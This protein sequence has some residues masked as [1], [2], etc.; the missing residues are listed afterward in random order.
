MANEDVI[1]QHIVFS[2]ENIEN[3][4]K[5]QVAPMQRPNRDNVKYGTELSD[6]V[7]I[8]QGNFEES[9]QEKPPEFDPAFIFKIK[10]D[11]GKIGDDD[12]QRSGI[13]LLSENPDGFVVL[14]SQ[15]QLKTFQEKIAGYGEEIAG[16]QKNPRYAWIAS[17]ATEMGLWNRKDRI[18][19]KLSKIDINPDADYILDVELWHYGT[20]DACRVRMQELHK[21]TENNGGSLFDYYIGSNLSV[22]R[23]MV[24]GSVL[25]LLL[26]VEIIERID[27]PPQPELKIA[28]IINTP[29]DDFPTPITNPPEGSPGICIVDSGIANGHPMLGAAIGDTVAI[30][31]SLG[32]GLDDNGHGTRVA[33]IALYGNVQDCIQKLNFSPQFF[34][35]GARVTNAQNRFD[36][37]HL[38]VKQMD[39]AIRYFHKNY[40]CRIFNISLGD[41][42]LIYDDGKPSQWA[43]ILDTLAQEL[44]ILIVV[45][46][47][48]YDNIF[49]TNG[50][51][52]DYFQHHYPHYLLEPEARILEPATAVNVLT[53]GA[54]AQ[55]AASRVMIDHPDDPAIRCLANIDQ[56]SPFTRSGFGVNNSIKPDV[57]EYGGNAVWDGHG[58]RIWVTDPEISIVS[59]NNRFRERLFTVGVGTSYAAPRI[60]HLAGQILKQYPGIS[61]NLIRALIASSACVPSAFSGVLDDDETLRLCGYGRPEINK[62]LYSTDSRVTLI[63]DDT[64]GIDRI[65][66][67]KV[68]IP[69]TFKDT[70]G[71]RSISVTLAFDPP[72]RYTRK[73]YIGIKMDFYLIRG[74]S[75]QTIIDWY[76]ARPKDV[77]FENIEGKYKCDMNPSK[78]RRGGGTL[79]KATFFAS[80]NKS[81]SEYNGDIFHLLV[82][83]KSASWMSANEQ[84]R[85]RYALAVTLEHIDTTV[86][87]YNIIDQ[88]I[89]PEQRVRVR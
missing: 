34:L 42:E 41:P 32:T 37:H 85:Q 13:T 21:F 5:K 73:G 39:E 52:A 6:A 28:Q 14:F 43:Q 18:G 62:A 2:K 24:K 35:F 78:T 87:L 11:K 29:L 22:A 70:T 8:L 9:I 75:T 89:R 76:S 16:E 17:L 23:I 27:F 61:A 49:G 82:R 10:I 45:S 67:Y 25:N 4:R 83:C 59:T 63:A 86:D 31:A 64:I 44:D 1:R 36:D 58:R 48:N 79:Q 26:G 88:R 72:V 57:C 60:A 84:E 74:L 69:D 65:H 46:A 33:G 50:E 15:D 53:V 19:K 12:W 55:T 38:I 40:G 51:N 80:R 56:P 71:K 7:R 47:G 20:N 68:P 81:F 66:I 54:L 30:P 3:P 77:E